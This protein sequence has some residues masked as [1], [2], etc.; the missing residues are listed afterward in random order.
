MTTRFGLQ[1]WSQATDWPGF[2][3]AALAAEATGWDSVWTWDH[4]LA[5]FGPWEQPILEGWTTLAAL[6]PLTKRVRLGLMVGANTFRNPGLTAKL[7]TTLDHVS[8]GRAVLGIGGAWF[9]REHE[10]FGI[11]FGKSPGE[12]LGWLDESVM[13]MRRLLDGER[14]DHD[15]PRYTMR[16]AL[17]EPRPIQPH[18]PILIG[19][20]GR[21]KTLRTVAQRADAWNNSGPIEEIRD[22]LETLERHC[23]EVGRDIATIERTVSFHIILRDSAG[24]ARERTEELLRFNGV[25]PDEFG[26]AVAGSPAEVADVLRPFRDLG[27]STFIVRMPAPYDHETIE[28]MAEVGALLDG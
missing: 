10:A 24:A 17:C 8:G 25:E 4:L 14:V 12:R 6:G 23:A 26:Q 15:G 7:A 18:L 22:A 28:R 3:D 9:E 5:I 21:T 20:G 16:D 19:G 11:D 1:L 2:R 13:L 27:F